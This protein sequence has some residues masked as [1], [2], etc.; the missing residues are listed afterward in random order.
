MAGKRTLNAAQTEALDESE[1]SL[2]K[3]YDEAREKLRA[4]GFGAED[5]PNGSF[6]CLRC[7]CEGFRR[8]PGGGLRCAQPGCGHSFFR[9]DVW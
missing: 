5:Q 9:H 4:A 2:T 6:G 7:D 8:P 3:A 1:A